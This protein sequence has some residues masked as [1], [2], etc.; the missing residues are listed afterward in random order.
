[1]NLRNE[2]QFSYWQKSVILKW[3][4]N[5]QILCRLHKIGKTQMLHRIIELIAHEIGHNL[6]GHQFF[7]LGPHY[8]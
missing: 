2:L 7:D 1:M 5:N 4:N 6:R 3:K 8:Q